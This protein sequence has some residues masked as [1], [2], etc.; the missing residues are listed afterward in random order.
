MSLF[1]N[2]NK[3]INKEEIEKLGLQVIKDFFRI[4]PS[5]IKPE[6]LKVL[7]QKARLGMQFEKEYNLTK[8]AVEMNYLRIFKMISQD[9]KELK[10]YIKQTMPHY[11]PTK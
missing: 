8:R 4:D 5:I 6:I 7:H 2:S 3:E 10:K 9:K 1:K 11:L